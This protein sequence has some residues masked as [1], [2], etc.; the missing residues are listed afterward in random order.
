MAALTGGLLENGPLSSP[1]V[2]VPAPPSAV[3]GHRQ[4]AADLGQVAAGRRRPR[5]AR[6]LDRPEV[7]LALGRAVDHPLADQRRRHIRRR[8]NAGLPMLRRKRIAES[9]PR[10]LPRFFSTSSSPT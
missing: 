8:V 3:H 1:L 10:W 5:V 7:A 9:P 6:I 4:D 2:S